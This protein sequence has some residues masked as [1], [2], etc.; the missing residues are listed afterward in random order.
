LRAAIA[1]YNCG[2]G[3]VLRALGGT[4][5]RDVDYFTAHRNYSADVL[6]RA[7]FFQLKGWS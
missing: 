7:S 2:P 5:A 6:N 1:G 3:N 4:P